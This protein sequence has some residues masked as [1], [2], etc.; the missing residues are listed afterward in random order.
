[1]GSCRS[2]LPRENRIVS[3]LNINAIWTKQEGWEDFVEA[4]F[5]DNGQMSYI[6][7][8]CFGIK[9]CMN[10]TKTI[11]YSDIR[12][13]LFEE[14]W[15]KRSKTNSADNTPD[16]PEIFDVCY[17]HLNDGQYIRL[18]PVTQEQMEKI[19]I[20]VFRNNS[21]NNKPERQNM[22]N[23][24][25]PSDVLVSSVKDG[26]ESCMDKHVEI[27]PFADQSSH[28]D[29]DAKKNDEHLAI[30]QTGSFVQTLSKFVDHNVTIAP[31]SYQ[32]VL[33]D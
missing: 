28:G 22:S 2:Y 14:K 16:N 10:E 6:E 21:N 19:K 5:Y 7:C 24:L 18:A 30:A 17:I 13:V 4:Q 29:S 20:A 23:P 3:D 26:N 32:A 33:S 12:E 31:G 15:R 9:S 27:G 1:M 8:T 25:C 11:K